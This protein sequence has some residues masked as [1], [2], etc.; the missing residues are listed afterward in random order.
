MAIGSGGRD[1]STIAGT[2][3]V[4][5]LRS[6]RLRPGHPLGGR[7]LRALAAEVD[8]ARVLQVF[9]EYPSR[10]RR[11]SAAILPV[12]LA[13]GWL[14]QPARLRCCRPAGRSPTATSRCSTS[15]CGRRSGSSRRSGSRPG[16]RGC[17]AASRCSRTPATRRSIRRAGWS[18]PSRPP[19]C[20]ACWRCCTA[21]IAF[22]GAWRLAR[23][24]GCGRG[25][26]ALA[27]G[28]VCRLRGVPL[29][30]Q[31]L[32]ALLQHGLVPLGAPVGGPGAARAGGARER[33]GG[34]RRS[35]PAGRSPSSSSTASPRRW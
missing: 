1:N 29:A 33:P 25:A 12:L 10:M 2:Y 26:A 27:G 28:G 35:S 24:F 30:A 23:H 17:T 16:T 8:A 21:A 7:L 9:V 32:H 19:T 22:A 15:R 14:A 34:G 4:A 6:D 31:R 20:S 11:R 13:A 5:G 3:T 18:S